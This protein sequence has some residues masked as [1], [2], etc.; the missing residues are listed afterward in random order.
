MWADQYKLQQ[1]QAE[2]SHAQSLE[3]TYQ[4]LK[5]KAD[6]LWNKWQNAVAAANAADNALSRARGAYARA[7]TIAD[8]LAGDATA[9]AAAAAAAENHYQKL[10]DEYDRQQ[11]AKRKAKKPPVTCS[12]S[13][14]V[15]PP[16]PR[17]IPEPLPPV[18]GPSPTPGPGPGSGSGS[19]PNPSPPGDTSTPAP[20][21]GGSGQGSGGGGSSGGGQTGA[22]ECPGPD[23]AN[24]GL[25]DLVS[26]RAKDPAAPLL[27]QRIGGQPSVKFSNGPENEFDAV[28]DQYVAQAKP[29]NFRLGSAFRNQAQA[30]FEVAIQSGRTPYFQFNGPPDRDV[31][32]ALSR[33]AIRYGIEPVIDLTPLEGC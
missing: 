31:L 20:D 13:C 19:N 23:D 5:S 24:G 25:G 7:V 17:P 18:G 9:A 12:T 2:L 3:H 16:G 14:I 15:P 21:P 27:A 22:G 32:R 4:K 11:K 6:S 28:S 33:Y 1:A 10:K 8:Q 29:A 30:T 26:V